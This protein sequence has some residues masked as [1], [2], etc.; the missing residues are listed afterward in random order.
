MVYFIVS[1]FKDTEKD[2]T[3]YDDYIQQVRP[4]VESYGG[5]YLIRS[6]KIALL[7]GSWKPDRLIIIQWDTKEHLET[8]FA[9]REYRKIAGKRENSVDSNAIIVEA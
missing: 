5:T 4:I 3:Q 2:L 1:V 9:S 7:S 8:C 6:E